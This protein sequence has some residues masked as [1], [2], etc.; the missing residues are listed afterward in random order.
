MSNQLSVFKNEEFGNV[1]TIV[2]LNQ[3]LFCGTDVAKA[4]GYS[5]PWDAI[6]RHCKTDG[7]VKRECGSKTVIM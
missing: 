6:R 5:N 2:E 4:F 7:I 3:V 1:R